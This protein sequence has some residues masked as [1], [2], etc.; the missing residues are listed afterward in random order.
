[1]HCVWCVY[2]R[3]CCIRSKRERM[4]FY[5]C[6]RNRFLNVHKLGLPD[7]QQ[8]KL[9]IRIPERNYNFILL[10]SWSLGNRN[11]QKHTHAKRLVCINVYSC[12]HTIAT[13]MNLAGVNEHRIVPGTASRVV[14]CGGVPLNVNIVYCLCCCVLSVLF[15]WFVFLH[16]TTNIFTKSTEENTQSWIKHG[17]VAVLRHSACRSFVMATW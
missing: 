13:E 8:L 1:M 11:T 9:C 3:V 12:L 6:A 10:P 2:V 17:C 16:S 5:V 14:M 15:I 4:L 7:I